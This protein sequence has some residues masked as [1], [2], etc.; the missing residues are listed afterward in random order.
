MKGRNAENVETK[1]WL[2]TGMLCLISVL[3]VFVFC[4]FLNNF[5]EKMGVGELAAETLAHLLSSV[6]ILA[7]YWKLYGLQEFGLGGTNFFRGLWTGGFMAFL[8]ILNTLVIVME[9]LEYPVVVPK[10][11]DVAM[12]VLDEAFVG[13]FEEF[14]YRGLLLHILSVKFKKY[15]FGGKMSAV[16]ISSLL[17]GLAHLLNLQDQPVNSTISQV[18]TSTLCGIYWAIL[19]LRTNNIWVCVLYHALTNLAASLTVLFFEVPDSSRTDI[20]VGDILTIFLS[21]LVILAVG[22][23]LARKL[24]EGKTEKI[25]MEP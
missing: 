12:V 6:V 23:F 9:N 5:F 8:T 3:G 10:A 11:G 4:I 1:S 22:L 25:K 15:G 14:L 17:F 20:S 2:F 21:N 13:I 19:Y 7:V 24:R 16:F 18:L